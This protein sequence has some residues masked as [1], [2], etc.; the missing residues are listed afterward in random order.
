MR[1]GSGG[2]AI[3]SSPTRDYL[4][5][6]EDKIDATGEHYD[7]FHKPEWSPERL[8]GQMYVGHLSV[9]RTSLVRAVGGVPRGLRRLA[10]PR[11]GAAGHRAGPRGRAH[12][13]DPLPL[14]RR[15][16][17]RRRRPRTRSR[18]PGRPAAR[19]CTSTSTAR[20]ISGRRRVRPAARVLPRGPRGQTRRRRSASSSRPAA[21]PGWSGGSAAASSSTWSRS[22]V[23]KAGHDRL[24]VRR[25]VRH[26]H[27]A[28]RFSTSSSRSPAT[29]WCWCQFTRAVQLQRQ[30]QRGLP[31]QPRA[32]SS[33]C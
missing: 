7:A 29:G 14:A 2:G 31:G 1:S 3:E 32:R 12:A 11:P 26:R 21:G 22:L 27:P 20:G 25:R 28:R 18:T 23:D 15:R 13:G 19:P 10:G 5:S 33:C 6:D 16:R 4:Y 9:M 8:R 30:V 17:V 24:R